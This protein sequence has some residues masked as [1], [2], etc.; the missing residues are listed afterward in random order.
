MLPF[1]ASQGPGP[2]RGHRKPRSNP[3]RGPDYLISVVPFKLSV[4]TTRPN[5]PG[6]SSRS[7]RAPVSYATI[8]RIYLG[9]SGPMG[10][11]TGTRLGPFQILSATGAGGMGEVYKARD[12]RLDRMVAFKILAAHLQDQVSGHRSLRIGRG[13]VSCVHTRVRA[14]FGTPRQRRSS[15][16]PEDSRSSRH[17]VERTHRRTGAPGPRSRLRQGDSAK[18]RTAY[19]GFLTL[20][21]DADPDIPV[22]KQGKPEY[23]KL[24]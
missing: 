9:V 15:R 24:Q 11:S 20:W 16:V 23:A 19:Q 7:F 14:P 6:R 12:T 13:A 5:W 21:K 10:L 22:L 17:R 8:R 2:F 1:K 18:A 3:C 4:G